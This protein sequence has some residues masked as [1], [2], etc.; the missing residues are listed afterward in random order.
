MAKQKCPECPEGAP[1]WLVSYGDMTT[2]L[3]CFFVFLLVTAKVDVQKLT[4]A[5]GYMA[6][7]MGLL[8]ENTSTKKQEDQDN[9]KVGQ[10][11]EEDQ[12]TSIEE[13]KKLSVG[14]KELFKKG[15][16]V[17]QM[18]KNS[19]ESILGFANQVRGLRNILEVR[20][21]TGKNEIG[22]DSIFRDEMELSIERARAIANYLI[23]TAKIR[24]ER[25][26][27]V[28]CGSNE[29]LESNLWLTTEEKNRRVEIRVTGKYQDF[30]PNTII[31]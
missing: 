4:A 21:H 27:I 13:G 24:A 3:L 30:N 19:T 16:A 26:R 14:G 6:H 22:K 2:L 28:G 31:K 17:L 5:S 25:I 1:D 29:R 18:D 15:D 11:G 7:K 12:V 8:P 20:G 23:D 10:K 9:A